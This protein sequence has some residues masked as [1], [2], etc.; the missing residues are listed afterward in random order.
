MSVGKETIVTNTLKTIRQDVKQETA[1][2][3][4]NLETHHFAVV[5][6]WFAILFAAEAD[7]RLVEIDQPAIGLR[8]DECTRQDNP[9]RVW[10]RRAAP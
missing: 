6:V 1:Y 8:H 7:V 2:E 4:A 9:I 3:L 10:D 5:T